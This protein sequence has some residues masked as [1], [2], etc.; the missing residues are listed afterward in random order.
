MSQPKH[1]EFTKKNP[2]F[3]SGND[4]ECIFVV[5]G[6]T[7]NN[8]GSTANIVSSTANF[9]ISTRGPRWD[10][11]PP[12]CVFYFSRSFLPHVSSLSQ[13]VW[14]KAYAIECKPLGWPQHIGHALSPIQLVVETPVCRQN[15]AAAVGCRT[16]RW[17][18]NVVRWFNLIDVIM[19]ILWTHNRI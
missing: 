19:A 14:S 15:M 17:W 6:T 11:V 18:T 16:K 9:V 1:P 8:R 10:H 5:L 4:F 13:A 3:L 12:S 7:A 2:H